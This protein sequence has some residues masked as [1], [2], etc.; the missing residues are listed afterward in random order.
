MATTIKLNG[1]YF[2]VRRICN[3]DKVGYF[4]AQTWHKYFDKYTPTQQGILKSNVH[5]EPFKVIYDSPYA[6]Y[7]HEGI[8]YIDPTINASG[9]FDVDTGRWYSHKGV[10]KIPTDEKLEYSREQNPLATSHWEVA[11]EKAFKATVA[12]EVTEYIRRLG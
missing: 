7:M 6:H 12:Q 8:K 11:A 9:W 3:S 1:A 2:K 4:L 5:Y 10:I